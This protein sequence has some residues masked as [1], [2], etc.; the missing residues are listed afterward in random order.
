MI[1][2]FR[3][4]MTFYTNGLSSLGQNALYF[5]IW[6]VYTLIVFVLL[7]LFVLATFNCFLILLVHRSKSLRG[8]LTNASSIRRTKVTE[9]P[10]PLANYERP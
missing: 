7:P 2:L 6:S 9:Q 5:N 4:Q 1:N 10:R 3:L 8:D